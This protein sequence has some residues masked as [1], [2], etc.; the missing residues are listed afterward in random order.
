MLRLLE[1]LK[2]SAT[3]NHSGIQQRVIRIFFT[4]KFDINPVGVRFT[5]ATQNNGLTFT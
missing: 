1:N 4:F 2:E 3:S 5:D